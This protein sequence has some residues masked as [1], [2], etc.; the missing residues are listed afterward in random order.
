MVQIVTSRSDLD[1]RCARRT[2]GSR[3]QRRVAKALALVIGLFPHSFHR[4]LQSDLW[5]AFPVLAKG[6]AGPSTLVKRPGRAYKAALAR[7]P[8]RNQSRTSPSATRRACGYRWPPSGSA[9]VDNRRLVVVRWLNTT[10]HKAPSTRP[11]GFA[12]SAAA[13]KAA[14]TPPPNAR[15]SNTRYVESGNC[16]RCRRRLWGSSPPKSKV[17]SRH[18]LSF[19]TYFCR[20]AMLLPLTTTFRKYGVRRK[21]EQESYRLSDSVRDFREDSYFRRFLSDRGRNLTATF[22]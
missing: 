6:V 13:E 3:P 8:W 16:E 17:P 10:G 1:K 2:V 12:V 19:A 5:K 4:P 20:R 21:P 9:Q 18:F 14:S 11:A 22:R 15:R 7:L